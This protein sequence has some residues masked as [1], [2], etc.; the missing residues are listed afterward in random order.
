MRIHRWTILAVVVCLLAAAHSPPL[1]AEEGSENDKTLYAL[2]VALSQRLAGMGF[3]EAE[4]ARV[5]AG[6]TD[7]LLGREPGVDLTVYGPKIDTM[8]AARMGDLAERQKATGVAYLE[9]AAAEP[10]AQRTDSGVIYTEVAAGD[11]AT[12]GPTDT[13]KLHYRG[14]LIDGTEFD[15]SI[16]GDP[17]TFQVGGVIAC[18]GE[19]VQRMR[20][21][22]KSKLVCPADT[23]YGDRGAPPQILPGA[24]LIFEVEL[25]EV[26]GPPAS[27]E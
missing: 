11:G 14:T 18:F 17:A 7:G 21:G 24:T 9:K 27:G 26:V 25:L 4:A 1:R 22:G 13:V 19:G 12:P 15:S 8:L 2:G 5:A 20:V 23:A 3:S 16:G 10:G 6:L